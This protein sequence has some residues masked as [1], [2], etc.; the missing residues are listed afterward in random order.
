MR[1]FIDNE[2][3]EINAAHVGLGAAYREGGLVE[4]WLEVERYCARRHPKES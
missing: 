4:L 3:E 2:G 1:R